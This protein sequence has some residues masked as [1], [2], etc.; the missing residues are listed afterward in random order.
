MIHFPKVSISEFI[1]IKSTVLPTQISL[2]FTVRYQYSK[3]RK[4][5]EN[6]IENS[7]VCRHIPLCEIIQLIF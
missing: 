2:T 5:G 7:V 4:K 6:A 1:Q 3:R